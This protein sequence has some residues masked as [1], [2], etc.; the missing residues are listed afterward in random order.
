MSFASEPALPSF[1]PRPVDVA[2]IERELARLLEGPSESE[3]APQPIT[4]A[5]MSNLIIY[6]D[7]PDPLRAIAD[8]L[9][10]IAERHPSRVLLLTSRAGETSAEIEATVSAVCYAVGG[11]RQVCS[12]HVEVSAAPHA[13]RRLP[14]IVRPLLIGDLPTALWWHSPEP[15]PL[16]GEPFDALAE[17][18]DRVIYDSVG[19]PDPVRG[20][21]ATSEW[22]ARPH[23]SVS[24]LA[25]LRLAE[26]RRLI[27]ESLD[28]A[29][30]PEAL[31]AISEVSVEHG[32]HALPEAWLLIG[33]LAA[34]LGWRAEA[35][36]VK[37]GV[38]M[39]F[40][41]AS[42]RGPVRASVRRLAEGESEVRC[43]S[44]AWQTESGARR[45]RLRALSAGRVG[46]RAEGAEERVLCVAKKPRVRLLSAQLSERR[47]PPLFRDA[48]ATARSMAMT[49]AQ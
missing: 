38:E 31:E 33:W 1:P 35:G 27:A 25:W 17:M 32:P 7:T 26:W 2:S 6:S 24:D 44:I 39:S 18:S 11:G 5:C 15:P 34:C 37:P 22:A 36:E 21:I 29:I 4:R 47:A 23:P 8:E 3:G 41:F 14:S 19:W 45:V 49:L 12:E 48:L 40:R 9:A 42:A 28:P 13:R 43:I 16:S 46:V 20:V 10:S 30:C